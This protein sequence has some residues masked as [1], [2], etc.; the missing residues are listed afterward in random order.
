M[1]GTVT[2]GGSDTTTSVITAF[3][4]AMIVWPEVQKKAQAQIDSV[5]GEDAKPKLG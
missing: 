4:Q 2:E 5:I 3:V 1:G